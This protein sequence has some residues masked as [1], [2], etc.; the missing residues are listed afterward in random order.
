M[1]VAVM[2]GWIVWIQASKYD[3]DSKRHMVGAWEPVSM[4]HMTLEE[5]EKALA[6]QANIFE[7]IL[8][9]RD[10]DAKRHGR[11]FL[12]HDNTYLYSHEFFCLPDTVDPRRP[13]GK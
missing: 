11:A 13:K 8:K 4:S 7:F 2:F 6:F 5:C 10:P 12:S 1:L 3:L 9:Q